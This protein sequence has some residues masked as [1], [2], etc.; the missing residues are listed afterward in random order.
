VAVAESEG[1]VMALL[2]RRDVDSIL[3]TASTFEVDWENG[4]A[5]R[6]HL[7][8]GYKGDDRTAA[9][10]AIEKFLNIGLRVYING[11]RIDARSYR[12]L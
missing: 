2:K 12:V 1:R 9:R 5:S 6:E 10:A 4:Y 8:R 11:K 3:A 7:M